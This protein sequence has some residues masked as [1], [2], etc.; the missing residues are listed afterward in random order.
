MPSFKDLDAD[1][2]QTPG[3]KLKKS[4]IKKLQYIGKAYNISQSALFE[5]WIDNEY[6][7]LK[8]AEKQGFE[9]I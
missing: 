9:I 8:K 3:I 6:N 5:M 7:R 2:K 1:K 4:S